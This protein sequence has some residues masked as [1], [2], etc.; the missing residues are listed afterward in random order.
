MIINPQSAHRVMGS[1]IDPHRHRVCIFSGNSLIDVEQI[2]VL[3][4]N[5]FEAEP[6]DRIRKV[7]VHALAV[8]T[9]AASLVAYFLRIPRRDVSG[10]QVAEAWVTILEVVVTLSFGDILCG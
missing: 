3:L 7:Q 8:R 1:W 10:N 4:T 2:A 9:H 6:V 5:R